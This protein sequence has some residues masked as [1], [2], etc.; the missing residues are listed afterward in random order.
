MWN[1]KPDEVDASYR[2][3]FSIMIRVARLVGLWA[4]RQR[5]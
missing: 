4:K 1:A 5:V 2:R 3:R